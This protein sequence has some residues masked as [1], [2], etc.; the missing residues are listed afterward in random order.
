MHEQ[1]KKIEIIEKASV[2]NTTTT[3]WKKTE[4]IKNENKQEENQ[5]ENNEN[6]KNPP[7]NN[8][9]HEKPVEK[10]EH[11]EHQSKLTS[12]KFTTTKNSD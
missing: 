2:E 1:A 10:A 4:N 3:V 12:F 6:P 9:T 5:L 7:P 11:P 8:T